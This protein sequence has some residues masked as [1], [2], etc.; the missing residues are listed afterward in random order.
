MA[1]GVQVPD[2]RSRSFDHPQVQA[3][4]QTLDCGFAAVADV[5]EECIYEALTSFSK[6]QLDAYLDAARAIG[7]LGRGAEPLLAFLE[8]WPTVV[9]LLQRRPGA[10]AAAGHGHHPG[11][12]EVA[13]QQGHHALPAN[14]GRR[15]AAPAIG[16]ADRDLHRHRPGPDART[17]GSIH[18]HHVTFPSPGLPHFFDQAP[19]LLGLLSTAGL[20]TGPTT[21]SAI[22][23]ATRSARRNISASNPPTAGGPAAR[24]PRHPV[25]RRRAQL[26]LYL[27]AVGRQRAAGALLHGLRR[28][29]QAGALLRQARACACRMCSTMSWPPDLPLEW[30]RKVPGEGISISGSTATALAHMVGHRRWSAAQIA[31]NWSPFQRMAVEFFEDCRVETLLMREYPGLRRI[32]LALHPVSREAPAIRPPRPACATA[33]RCS[34]APCST[35][36]TATR[37]R[38]CSTTPQRFHAALAD[39]ESSTRRW[40]GW[41]SPTSPKRGARATSCPGSISPTR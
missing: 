19:R 3:A 7:K 34:R 25:H 21:A 29:A 39:G 41:R 13:Q 4:W 14:P 30:G 23:P 26:D 2:A 22:T 11:H 5:F 17:S 10:F 8:E 28:I 33:W 9:E 15:R 38:T 1:T 37:T 12:A 32:F 31:D 6:P 36:A 20:R 16:R 18:G 27:R 24:T 40:P 35:P